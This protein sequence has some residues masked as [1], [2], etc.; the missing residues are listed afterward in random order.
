VNNTNVQVCIIAFG[1]KITCIFAQICSFVLTYG[2]ALNYIQKLF[3][4]SQ[5]TV[6][7]NVFLTLFME[8]MSEYS[9]NHFETSV[10]TARGNVVSDKVEGTLIA[11]IGSNEVTRRYGNNKTGYTMFP[12]A[13]LGD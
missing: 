6:F 8:I 4:A 13:F 10:N 5:K 2:A 9:E 11:V 12:A 1:W 7:I 3:P